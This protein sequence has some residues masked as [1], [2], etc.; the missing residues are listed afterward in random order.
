MERRISDID[1]MLNMNA[2]N[3]AVAIMEMINSDQQ[4]KPSLEDAVEQTLKIAE[5]LRAW[6]KHDIFIMVYFDAK[7]GKKIKETHAKFLQEHGFEQNEKGNFYA[8]MRQSHFG[9]LLSENNWLL[10]TF[11][12]R[13]EVATLQERGE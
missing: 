5:R 7:D 1:L 3:N 11:R 13:T 9:K 12:I 8:R 10:N 6:N 4:E 2:L